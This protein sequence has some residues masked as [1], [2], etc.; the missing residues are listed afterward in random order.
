MK[1]E[2][3]RFKGIKKQ[4]IIV[5]FKGGDITSDAGLLLFREIEKK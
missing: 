5:E 2:I 4:E 1:S 3:I